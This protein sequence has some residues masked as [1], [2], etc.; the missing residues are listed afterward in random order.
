MTDRVS[1]ITGGGG[2]MGVACARKLAAS[3]RLLLAEIDEARL[4]SALATLAEQGI[5]AE[6][7]IADVADAESVAALAARAAELGALGALVHT[8]GLSPT[9]GDG[10]R[11]MEVNLVGTAR[12]VEAFRPQCVAGSV[13]VLI[14][15]QAGH[16]ARA[17]ATPALEALL[18][19]PLDADLLARLEALNPG[20]VTPEGAYGC[21]KLGLLRMAER[22]A[23]AWGQSGG[24]IVSLSPGMID[25]GMGRREFEVQPMMTVMLEK[26]PLRRF[27]T[28]EEIADA[29]AF[30][31]S[32]A[33]T[34]ITGTDLLVDGGSTQAVRAMAAAASR[35]EA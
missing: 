26:T 6:T 10:R 8:A 19:A 22:E 31:C 18:D 20:F 7:C 15:S 33:A 17:G 1:V 29:V 16:F 35:G 32:D 27:G 13:A 4:E 9:H 5:E 34:F 28:A 25:T 12:L 21:S 30:L 11:I 2:D 24:R 3:G 14:A 23:E